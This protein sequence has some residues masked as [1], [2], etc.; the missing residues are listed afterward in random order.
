MPRRAWQ[1]PEDSERYIKLLIA[2]GP[3]IS[4]MTNG[5][6]TGLGLSI[7][8]KFFLENFMDKCV[9]TSVDSAIY[10]KYT[11]ETFHLPVLFELLPSSDPGHKKFWK[12]ET[13]SMFRLRKTLERCV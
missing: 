6:L 5:L 8:P 13:G 2:L 9:S 10:L 12:R 11:F 1:S 4:P 7:P 3:Q